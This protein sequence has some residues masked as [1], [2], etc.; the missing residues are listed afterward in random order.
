MEEERDEGWRM[1]GSRES[2]VEVRSVRCPLFHAHWVRRCCCLPPL[3]TNFGTELKRLQHLN[4]SNNRVSSLSSERLPYLSW[5][6]LKE[7]PSFFVVLRKS[8]CEIYKPKSRPQHLYCECSRV[9]RRK[10]LYLTWDNGFT[11]AKWTDNNP[12]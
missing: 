5:P 11:L 4:T 6:A 12:Q 10:H 8:T 2:A 3:P 7:K 9:W 1:G